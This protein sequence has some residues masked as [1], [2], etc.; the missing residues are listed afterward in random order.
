VQELKSQFKQIWF[1]D[2]E[3]SV[4]PGEFPV[5]ICMVAEEYYSRKRLSLWSDQLKA[6]EQAPFDTG[7]DSLFV[8][9]YSIAEFSC[10][11]QLGWSLPENV[12]D[13]FVEFRN[14]TNGL[15]LPLG[16][17]LLGALSYFGVDSMEALEKEQMR[18]LAIRGG[19]WTAEEKISL[20][21]YCAKDVEALRKLI[22]RFSKKIHTLSALNRGRYMKAASVIE[23]NGVPID[24]EMFKKFSLNWSY[25]Q[26]NIIKEID[27]EYGIFDGKTFKTDRWKKWLIEQK[28][29]WPELPSGTLDMREETFREMSKK[30]K[31]IAP[32][33]ELRATLAQMRLSDLA[34][35]Q[36]GRNR[37]SL[38][39]FRS[40][41]G[42]NQ[43]SSK[44]FIFGPAVWL[45]GLIK[46]KEGFGIAYIDWTQQEVGIAAA[47]SNDE[48]M[49]SAYSSGDCYLTFAKQAGA[50][51]WNAT[52]AS[53]P[54]IREQFKACVLA[55]QYGM[56]Q[57]S[58]ALRLGQP[59]SK[60][61]ELLRLH[62]EV[63]KKFWSWS[64]AALNFYLSEGHIKTPYGWTLHLPR[65]SYNKVN[66]RSVRNF[67]IQATGA[68]LLRLACC[69]CVENGIRVCAPVHDALLI[70]AKLEDLDDAVL[71]TQNAMSV[72]G[73]KILEG[74]K[75]RTDVKIFRYPERY[76]DE[77]GSV[78]WE[79]MVG[80]LDKPNPPTAYV[81]IP[82]MEQ[83]LAV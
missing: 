27:A 6:C 11:L 39:T 62:Q 52:K 37:A 1:V 80:L 22:I 10:F 59:V 74:F 19:P 60:A 72:A 16:N 77:R 68:E 51:P 46:P 53:H 8:A 73:E 43:P 58:L 63:Y 26:E 14:Q 31:K 38:S 83:Y 32:I 45:R 47:L 25:L 79:T 21:K 65:L 48:R 34:V 13:L 75:L 7:K 36:D 54:H 33:Y 82:P 28:I 57:D 71:T 15:T 30:D 40:K 81:P 18:D 61:R 4:K 23:C 20:L 56:G 67:P 76:M 24:G 17:S 35:G 44:S 66:P 29:S 55:V 50:V 49:K 69:Y 5:P 2:F 41:T 78:M 3:F 70:E 12:I 64:D 42:R 9:Y